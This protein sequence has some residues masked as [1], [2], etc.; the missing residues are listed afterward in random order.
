VQAAVFVEL[1]DARWRVRLFIDDDN[2]QR[3]LQGIEGL[4]PADRYFGA[5]PEVL[6]TL[7]ARVAANAL[8]LAR[9]EVPKA[10]FYLTGQVGGQPYSLDGEGERIIHAMPNCD[11]AALGQA[12]YTD[13]LVFAR[14]I[15][16]LEGGA[17]VNVG[18]AVI[19]P[20]VYLKA[21]SMARNLARQRGEGIRHFTTAV[22]DLVPLPENWRDGPPGKDD[23]LYYYRP[24]KTIL[25]RTVADGGQSYYVRGDFRQTIPALWH[26]L[27]H[28]GAEPAPLEQP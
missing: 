11:G 22:F 7:K 16:G 8:E 19:G 24:W 15:Q 25:V 27:V 10:P 17:F 9:H 1:A 12:S 2:F 28:G 6:R 23:P 13:F 26:R 14:P 3:T 5:A 4:V 18:S 20:E 21:L